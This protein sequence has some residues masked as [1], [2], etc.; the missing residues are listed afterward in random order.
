MLY[1]IAIHCALDSCDVGFEEV[2]FIMLTNSAVD[3]DDCT[4]SLVSEYTEQQL[5][6]PP[7]ATAAPLLGSKAHVITH[8]ECIGITFFLAALI[9]SQMIS[10]PSWDAL[11]MVFG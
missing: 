1:K 2:K 5:S 4:T 7:H 9:A 3:D 8:D 10:L 11:T 6:K